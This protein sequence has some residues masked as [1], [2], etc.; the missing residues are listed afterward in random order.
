MTKSIKKK[1]MFKFNKKKKNKYP[2]HKTQRIQ[3]IKQELWE[4]K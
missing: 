3:C 2:T 4:K 1:K